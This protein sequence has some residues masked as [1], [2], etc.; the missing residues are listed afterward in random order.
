M[1]SFQTSIIYTKSTRMAPSIDKDVPFSLPSLP[2][3]RMEVPFSMAR[4]NDPPSVGNY[5]ALIA[6]SRP[7]RG[8]IP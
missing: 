3:A 8:S 2:D 6:N 7:L 5:H 1:N 4:D